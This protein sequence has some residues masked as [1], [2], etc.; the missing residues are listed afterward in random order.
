MRG[1]AAT[2]REQACYESAQNSDAIHLVFERGEVSYSFALLEGG[3]PWKGRQE[4]TASAR[5]SKGLR[6]GSLHLG[7]SRAEVA[8]VLGKPAVDRDDRMEYRYLFKRKTGADALDV[9]AVIVAR[10]TNSKLS[11]LSVSRS[12]TY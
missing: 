9:S 3:P 10:F 1:Y 5:I 11:Y 12:E 7:Q 4:C 6:V 2:S 8:A